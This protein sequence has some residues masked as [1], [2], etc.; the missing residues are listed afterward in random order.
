MIFSIL[1]IM[2]AGSFAMAQPKPENSGNMELRDAHERLGKLM[3]STEQ[4]LKYVAPADAYDD[5]Q[6]AY[7]RLDLLA[8]TTE[9]GIRYTAPEEFPSAEPVFN[10]DENPPQYL[11]DI[12]PIIFKHYVPTRLR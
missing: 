1:A 2:V 11:A 3:A 10:D 6:S 7:D 8:E 5:I 12:L 9:A 4:D